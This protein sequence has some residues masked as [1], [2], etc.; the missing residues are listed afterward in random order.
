MINSITLQNRTQTIANKHKNLHATDMIALHSICLEIYEHEDTNFP[1][2]WIWS[3][4][5]SPYINCDQEH[6]YA[7]KK[8]NNKKGIS[9]KHTKNCTPQIWLHY[10]LFLQSSMNI[11]IPSSRL[12]EFDPKLDHHTFVVI[13]SI[14]MQSKKKIKKGVPQ[15][16]TKNCTP[17]LS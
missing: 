17:R 6:K 14:N 4:T 11:E 3:K 9:Q 1:S 16:H 5:G 15:K 7:K 10:I 2:K 13:K 8:N 12:N